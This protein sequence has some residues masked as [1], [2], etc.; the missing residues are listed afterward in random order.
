MTRSGAAP[1]DTIVLIHGLWMTP[2]CWENWVERYTA[3][4]YRVLAPAWPG[5]EDVAI[6]VI[7]RDP[8]AL[9]GIGV[10]EVVD[11]YDRIIRRLA[12]PPIIIGHSFGGLFTQILVDRG[13]GAAGVAIDSAQ[14]K[15]VLRLP[16]S[17]LRSAWPVLGNPANRTRTVALTH[18]P[19]HYG[20]ANALSPPESRQVYER[21]HIPGPGRPLFQAGRTSLRTR[22][23][24]WT[25]R[26][27]TGHRC[28]SWPA[29]TTTSRR[30]RSTA[31]TSDATA[32]RAPSPAI[33]SSRAAATRTAGRPSPT[34]PSTG[35]TT[36]CR[37]RHDGYGD[38][39][40]DVGQQPQ[41]LQDGTELGHRRRGRPAPCR[42]AR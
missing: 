20:F 21:Y 33:A 23:P 1:A 14:P 28:S 38:R 35:P 27:A 7:R 11:H 22:R 26:T 18:E 2:L 6:E 39:S 42:C 9:A 10:T 25:G 8:S 41:R 13:L 16:L 40:P 29:A 5:I 17:T 3:A 24:P 12:S 30:R 4:G 31:R 36:R 19:F 34:M 37:H 15:R 32:G